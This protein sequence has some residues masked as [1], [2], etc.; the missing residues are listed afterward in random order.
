M[1]KGLRYM[2]SLVLL[3]QLLAGQQPPTSTFRVQVRLVEVYATVY[4]HAGHYVDGLA[5]DRFEVLEDGK[6]QPIANFEANVEKLSCALLLDTTGSMSAVLPRLK[7][8]V[9][10]LIDSLGPHDSVAIYTF[11]RQV[12]LR[13]PFTT[14]KASAKRAVLRLRAEGETALFDSVSQVAQEV[15]A[16][17]GKKA[18]IVFT[19]GDDNASVLNSKSAVNR[20]KNLGIPLYTIAEGE[21]L[22]VSHLKKTL[23]DLSES[24]GALSYE[25]R[26]PEA[27][28]QIFQEISHDL[29]HLY[30]IS[31]KPPLGPPPGQWRKI[32]LSVKGGQDYRIRAKHGY[33]MD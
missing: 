12:T 29:Q 15:A 13:Q 7:N 23:K 33:A 26:K 1:R 27:I 10:R 6:A 11:D 24:T 8:A 22:E 21:A 17:P 4:D 28:D 19:D 32:D 25:A 14:D 5:R 2:A 31:Y 18:L 16:Q 30:L 9:T 3:V 20:A